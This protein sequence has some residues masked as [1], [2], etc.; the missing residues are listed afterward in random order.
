MWALVSRL[1]KVRLECY[2]SHTV[3]VSASRSWNWTRAN[4]LLSPY[5]FR[6]SRWSFVLC[7]FKGWIRYRIRYRVKVGPERVLQLKSASKGALALERG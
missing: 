1:G 3:M 2:G 4:Q 7:Y 5:L 6:G